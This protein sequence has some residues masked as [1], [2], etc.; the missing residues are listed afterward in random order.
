VRGADGKLRPAFWRDVP[1]R[2]LFE[3]ALYVS[4]KR[5]VVV[6]SPFLTIEE[7]Y[8]TAKAIRAISKEVRLVLGPVPIVGGDDHYPKNAKGQHVPPTKFTIHAEKCPNRKGVELIL[9]KF[10]GE[11]ISFAD[12]I[13]QEL[14]AIWF[15]GGYPNAEWVSA[16]IPENWVAPKFLAVQDL[17]QS[18]LTA[19]ASHV[20]PATTV[21]EKAGTY[22]SYTGA[23]QSFSPAVKP[24]QEIRS[25]LQLAYDLAGTKGLA[26]IATV[27]A[28]L[29]KE[30][31][32]FA[33]LAEAKGKTVTKK[34]ELATV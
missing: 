19:A 4:A 33:E 15:A 32:Q 3:D 10:Q 29:A 13:N 16:A 28:D 31:P 21:F 25:E 30:F 17:F 7:A 12:V 8:A 27:R 22:M 14:T 24:T 9:Q 26:N 2:K 18:K 11:V 5:A 1:V 20:L 34:L 23:I 6:L